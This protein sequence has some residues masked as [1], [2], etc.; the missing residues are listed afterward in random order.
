M[1]DVIRPCVLCGGPGT[2][3]LLLRRVR[4]EKHACE[5]C[6]SVL[7]SAKHKAQDEAAAARMATHQARVKTL[8]ALGVDVA[9]TGEEFGSEEPDVVRGRASRV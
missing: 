8:S 1:A 9:N 2:H 7:G 6:L 4:T 3:V 5:E